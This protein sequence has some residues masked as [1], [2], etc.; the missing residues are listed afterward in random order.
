MGGLWF[1]WGTAKDPFMTPKP[2]WAAQLLLVAASTPCYTK[3]AIWRPMTEQRYDLAS[4][5]DLLLKGFD[6]LDLRRLCH[7]VPDFRPVYERLAQSTGKAQIVDELI[8]Y[9]ERTMQLETLLALAKER[10][11]ARYDLHGPYYFDDP[12]PALEKQ[13]SDLAKRL[14]AITSP[15]SLTK[16]QQYRIALHWDELGRKDSLNSF[17]L[18]DCSLAGVDLAGA[19]LGGASLSG[20]DL[21]G[22]ILSGAYLRGAELENTDLLGAKLEGADLSGALLIGAS[23]TAA[24]LTEADL[25]GADLNSADL[26]GAD[27][28]NADLTGAALLGARLE[29]ADL[30]GAI[31]I[32]ADLAGAHLDFANL[33][34][35]TV[36][37]EQLAA[38]ESLEGATLPDGAKRQEPDRRRRL[39]WRW[40]P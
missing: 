34:R 20:A 22:A 28:N 8:T 39:P 5:R 13:V 10:N 9:A 15:G 18:D 6:D 21:R 24:D 31:L 26:A 27:L 12:T 32:G 29:R 7:D 38:A 36:T 19:N 3:R 14:A 23:L 30:T 11:R 40:R 1:V 37:E 35:A 2:Q 25:T 4:I 33:D 17:R 16:E